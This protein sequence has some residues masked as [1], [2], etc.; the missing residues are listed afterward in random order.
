MQVLDVQVAT[1]R[2]WNRGFSNRSLLCEL[3]MFRYVQKFR[4][5]EAKGDFR[6]GACLNADLSSSRAKISR[7]KAAEIESLC[8]FFKFMRFCWPYL[9][10]GSEES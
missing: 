9:W 2:V 5:E 8:G 7:A 1:G 6:M 4:P 3:V 10:S